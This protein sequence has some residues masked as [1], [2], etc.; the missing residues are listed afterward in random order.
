MQTTET[1]ALQHSEQSFRCPGIAP[2]GQQALMIQL[3]H[4]YLV[5]NLTFADQVNQCLD[6]LPIMICLLVSGHYATFSPFGLWL[7]EQ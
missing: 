5:I 1:I 2:A 7:A 3:N 4:N 6:N